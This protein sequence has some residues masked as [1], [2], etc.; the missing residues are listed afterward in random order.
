[1]AEALDSMNQ[2]QQLLSLGA[3]AFVLITGLLAIAQVLQLL[4]CLGANPPAPGWW[5]NVPQRIPCIR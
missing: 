3:L 4:L 5:G 2:V 1:M